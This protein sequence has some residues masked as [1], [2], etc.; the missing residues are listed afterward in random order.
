MHRRRF[1]ETALCATGALLAVPAV[2]AWL[3]R[4]D[5]FAIRPGDICSSGG[6]G[7]SDY[8]AASAANA[9]GPGLRYEGT[10]IL[11][12]GALREVAR[13]FTGVVPFLVSGGGCDDGIAAVRRGDAELGGMCCPVEGSR[14]MG[15][16]SALIAHDIKVAVVHPSNTIRDIGFGAL[17]DVSAG[18]AA[19]WSQLGGADRSIA[20]VVREHC[21]EYREPAKSVLLGKEPWHQKA[22]FVKTDKEIVDSVAR[23]PGALGIVSWVFAKPLVESGQLRVL[24]LDGVTPTADAVVAGRYP[25]HGPL[26]VVFSDW[27]PEM[28]PLFDFIYG[29]QGRSIIAENLVPVGRNDAGYRFG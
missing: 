10:H 18:H 28:G 25:L 26:S 29:P 20:L 1:I 9:A 22:L 11:T 3:G 19:R 14:G 16:K 2:T 13:Q 21:P 23:F 6:R 12:H 8:F 15:L 24:S 4:D 7:R 27:R 17:K 5:G